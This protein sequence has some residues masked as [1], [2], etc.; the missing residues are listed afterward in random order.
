MRVYSG[1]NP[2]TPLRE[3]ARYPDALI[4]IADKSARTSDSSKYKPVRLSSR[5]S[6]LSAYAV[7]TNYDNLRDS[8]AREASKISTKPCD[9]KRE[10]SLPAL[11]NKMSNCR[12]C[13]E[14]KFS[15]MRCPSVS[16]PADL[17]QKRENSFR[18]FDST[19]RSVQS[20]FSR[21]RGS[22]CARNDVNR[23]GYDREA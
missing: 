11:S 16:K 20:R 10:Q 14:K 8:P 15:L 23:R 5:T 17:L 18:S 9:D 6:R 7:E 13:L 4:K 19:V 12:I 3:L 21:G 2:R 1:Q 22:F